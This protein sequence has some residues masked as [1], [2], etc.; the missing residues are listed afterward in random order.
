MC[1]WTCPCTALKSHSALATFD[2]AMCTTMAVH[3]LVD[4]IARAQD[5]QQCKSAFPA[6]KHPKCGVTDCCT[7]STQDM[8]SSVHTELLQ[9]FNFSWHVWAPTGRTLSTATEVFV[10]R[11]LSTGDESF[12][13]AECTSQESPTNTSTDLSRPPKQQDWPKHTK[14]VYCSMQRMLELIATRHQAT[15]LIKGACTAVDI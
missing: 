12:T 14:Q 1:L 3:L 8:A 15:A 13:D 10:F 6:H 9:T 5:L 7:G 11:S 2:H 4:K